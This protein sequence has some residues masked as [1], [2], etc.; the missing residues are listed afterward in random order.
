MS[1]TEHTPEPEGHPLKNYLIIE[2]WFS[3][4]LYKLGLKSGDFSCTWVKKISPR[5]NLYWAILWQ[6]EKCDLLHFQWAR[7]RWLSEPL[8]IPSLGNWHRNSWEQPRSDALPEFSTDITVE[9]CLLSSFCPESS[10]P[11]CTMHKMVHCV[12]QDQDS[13]M[14]I[15]PMIS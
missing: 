3:H 2:I 1:G 13:S 14:N 8:N 9:D 7:R 4:H 10:T 5:D 11:P 12:H 6:K 15:S